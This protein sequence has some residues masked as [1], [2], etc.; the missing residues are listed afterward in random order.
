VIFRLVLLA[1]GAL[2]LT[3]SLAIE[4]PERFA[5]TGLCALVTV[6]VAAG[7]I[8]A[9]AVPLRRIPLFCSV[10]TLV[11]G[12]ALFSRSEV[13]IPLSAGIVAAQVIGIA[14]RL[15]QPQRSAHGGRGTRVY[16][17][18]RWSNFKERQ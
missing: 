7:A 8:A 18:S 11:L 14:G 4:R 6:I 9:D 13:H 15:T 1:V 3:G 16:T 12:A 2:A 5:V 10:A 17:R